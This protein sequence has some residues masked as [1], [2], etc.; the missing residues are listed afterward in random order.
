[1]DDWNEGGTQVELGAEQLQR[2]PVR[3]PV[4][5]AFSIRDY[6]LFPGLNGCGIEHE[7][8]RGVTII[9]GVNGLG[10]TTLLTAIYRALTGPIDSGIQL[11]RALGAQQPRLRSWDASYFSRRVEDGAAQAHVELTLAFA[12]HTL[13]LKRRLSDLG[14]EEFQV[15]DQN[16]PTSESH[17]QDVILR[18][19][20]LPT[21]LDFLI[22]LQYVVFVFEDRPRLVWDPTA[23][24]ELFRFLVNPADEAIAYRAA[25]EQI[26]SDDSGRRNVRVQVN[27]L[28][29]QLDRARAAAAADRPLNAEIDARV[30]EIGESERAI[31][32]LTSS[33]T[34]LDAQRRDDRERLMQDRSSAVAVQSRYAEL[35]QELLRGI[36]PSAEAT[37]RFVLTSASA[38]CLI[39]GN[40]TGAAL[41]RIR[42]QIERERCPFCDST[43]TPLEPAIEAPAALPGAELAEVA[44]QSDAHRLRIKDRE[45]RLEATAR[46]HAEA[47]RQ[48]SEA[49]DRQRYLGAELAALRRRLPPTPET[50][51]QMTEQL[52]ALE[53]AAHSLEQSQVQAE[54]TLVDLVSLT[55]RRVEHLSDTIGARF[56]LYAGAFLEETCEL[57][58]EPSDRRIGQEGRSFS[59]PR[60][61][62]RMSSA[63]SN[64][65]GRP[66]LSEEHVSESQKEFIDLAFRMALIDAV[67]EGQG[68]TIVLETPEASLDQIFAYRAG[69]MFGVFAHQ[70]AGHGNRLVAT[71]NVTD[72]PMIS[73]M[74]GV[75]RSESGQPQAHF[76]PSDERPSH[77]VDLLAN[78]A[79]TAALDR[80]GD[81]YRE[82]LDNSIF[83]E[84]AEVL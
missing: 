37:A 69:R 71:S 34:A 73:A 29:D 30:I 42:S 21:F 23:Q 54:A 72:G 52:H 43:A 9:A 51:G 24:S 63:L 36:F 17:Y 62:I 13:R 28:Q 22:L 82:A 12:E 65:D 15:D 79:A 48:L 46:E 40:Q 14:L 41:E 25:F 56:S 64:G 55:K 16:Q 3:L 57:V 67:A 1:L 77:V 58:Y 47:S 75:G 44:A 80:Y 70:G 10:K 6:E 66:R 32:G 45:Q 35:E 61:H 27:R 76:V 20:G 74:L 2:L 59:F 33:V 18:L 39:C 83:P 38:G 53:E 50:M 7:F 26:A 60:F 8:P 4:L 49:I 31:A 5:L 68:A 19:S 78:A 81:Q 84:R 11:R